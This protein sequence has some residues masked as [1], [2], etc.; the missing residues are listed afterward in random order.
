MEVQLMKVGFKQHSV[1]V[2]FALRDP[3]T[4]AIGIGFITLDPELQSVM[5]EV[6]NKVFA[7]DFARMTRELTEVK[8]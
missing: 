5:G 7:E 2:T 8:R 6:D 1:E 3:A 4:R